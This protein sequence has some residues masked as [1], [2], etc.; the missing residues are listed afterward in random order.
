MESTIKVK[1]ISILVLFYILG[2]LS[3]ILISNT[4]KENIKLFLE[5]IREEKVIDQSIEIV[6]VEEEVEDIP[7]VQQEIVDPCPV[8]V[9]VSG[10]VK[11]PG[12]Y[13]LETDSA[14]VD[15]IRKAG[16]LITGVASKYMSMRINLS[17]LLIDNTKIYIPFEVDSICETVEFK[18]PMKVIEI[19]QPPVIDTEE[20]NTCVN[21]NTATLEQ[22]D[23]LNGIGASTAQKIIDGRPYQQLEDL[24]NV[25]GIGQS[26][27]DK[28]KENICL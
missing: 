11:N 5:T 18:I 15:A 16:G 25:S 2:L 24:L 21:I 12:V 10:A 6:T 13:C 4:E 8:R 28:F 23:T 22:L 27:F 14:V 9:D 3:G 1:N 19:V 7:E 26:T 17:T 20:E